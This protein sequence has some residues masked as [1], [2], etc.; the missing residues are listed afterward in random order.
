MLISWLGTAK[1]DKLKP[2]ALSYIRFLELNLKP[3]IKSITDS[4]PLGIKN[5]ESKTKE[6]R[7]DILCRPATLNI[8]APA[9]PE[10]ETPT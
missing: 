3:G 6:V 4:P 2:K 5:I 1:I 9:P 7:F 10:P 8:A